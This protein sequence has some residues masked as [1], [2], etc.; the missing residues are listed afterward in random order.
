MGNNSKTV[1][2]LMTCHNRA[3]LTEVAIFSAKNSAK[4]A[5]IDLFWAVTNDGSSDDT[6]QV[7]IKNCENLRIIEGDGNLYWSR[8][9]RAAWDGGS[10]FFDPCDYV[11]W[12]NDDVNL[13]EI[14]IQEMIESMHIGDASIVAGA[15]AQD[16]KLEI[17]SY[18]GFSLKGKRP[19]RFKQV[20]PDCAVQ[21]IDSFNGNVVLMKWEVAQKIDIQQF[22]HMFGDI[23][24]GLRARRAG[25]NLVTTRAYVGVCYR[26]SPD[27]RWL[28]PE[29]NMHERLSEFFGKK[30][31]NYRDLL[32]YN[33]THCGF[34][35]G[36]LLSNLTYVKSLARVLV[37]KK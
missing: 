23:D 30:G 22:S 10:G 18:G 4:F 34:F 28:A 2:V 6:P 7:L 32:N 15:C 21:R 25:L 16:D 8:G 33:M 27:F 11:L 36:F 26:D 20:P 19:T 5:N 31:L 1:M 9:M 17:F 37:V 13:L 24:F 12:L 3:E 29:K 35:T 14:G